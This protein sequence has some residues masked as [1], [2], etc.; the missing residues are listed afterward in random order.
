MPS[1]R[2]S[3]VI[4]VAVAV[5]VH[6]LYRLDDR[7]L[8]SPDEG[9]Y[10]EIGREM[11]ESGDYVTPRLNYVRYFEKPPLV[12]WMTAASIGLLGPNEWA[13]R[14]PI[15]LTALLGLLVT[16]RLG[17]TMAGPQVGLIAVILLSTNILYYALARFLVLD[18]VLT[19]LLT[20]GL[21]C[22]YS[23][24]SGSSSRSFVWASVFL[25]LATLTKGPIAL[26]LPILIIC[27]LV[28]RKDVRQRL[29]TA[30]WISMGA[31]YLL[32]S[33]PWFVAI[34][35]AHPEFLSFFFIH[36]HI[37]RFLKPTHLRPGP[38]WYFIP[39]VVA[40]FF[41]WSCL[42]PAVV[43]SPS[44]G[45]ASCFLWSW[46]VFPFAFFSISQSKLPGYI[47]PIFPAL[48]I[49][50]ACQIQR[51]LDEVDNQGRRH[52]LVRWLVFGCFLIV[53][54]VLGLCYCASCLTKEAYPD[55]VQIRPQVLLVLAGI[56]LLGTIVAWILDSGR[57]RLALTLLAVG[58]GLGLQWTRPVVLAYEIQK[59]V[60]VIARALLARLSPE[61]QVVV[62]GTLESASGL[63][64]YLQRGVIVGGHHFGELT[65]ARDT[66]LPEE[67]PFFADA[68]TAERWMRA[69]QPRRF[70]VTQPMVFAGYFSKLPEVRPRRIL[71]RG[72]LVLFANR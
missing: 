71:R 44:R 63:P 55:L 2:R 70:F 43:R 51:V 14:L 8:W 23:A 35:R 4:I 37:D 33:A 15:A 64:F 62:Y 54:T 19:V 40:G 1:L 42:L 3:L 16:Y 20:A 18:M 57:I 28:L 65:F 34:G 7:S 68:T 66:A 72:D 22:L 5:S 30:P 59:D 6:L 47:L 53:L 21:A 25:G 27:P 10:A 50:V 31:A 61:D 24:L 13:V 11:F 52:F 67:R 46:V 56:A 29:A 48:A 60:R 41:P 58:S 69:D 26:V 45:L 9:R 12:Y 39:I 38:L 36:E 17:R 49:L 32:V